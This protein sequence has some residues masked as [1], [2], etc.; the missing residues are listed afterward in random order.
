M[1]RFACGLL[2]PLGAGLLLGLRFPGLPA[3]LAQP[4]V[5]WGVPLSLVGLLLRAGLHAEMVLAAVVTA[6]ASAIGLLLVQRCPPL[7]RA[8][9]S[10]CLRLGSVVGNTG[11][12]GIPV[13]LALLPP[14]ALGFSITYDLVGT[15]IT[16]SAGPLLVAG[17]PADGR[18]AAAALAASP[19]F[20]GLTL[21][22]ALQ[23]SPWGTALGTLLWGPSQVLV[24]VALSVVGMRLGVTLGHTWSEARA[25]S[26]QPTASRTP[27]RDARADR[28]LPVAVA[29]K[30]LVLPGVMLGLALLLRLPPL[31][32][33]ALVLQAGAPTAIS[34]LLLAEL[35]GRDGEA[36][37]QLVLVTTLLALASVPLWWRL[38]LQVPQVA[39][40]AS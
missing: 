32:R 34:A 40:L 16:W 10:P 37:A 39:A 26:P 38:L 19:A 18:Q 6:L 23:L 2:L 14:A 1:L 9:P 7:R 12:F 31:V 22:L 13:A 29:F 25:T 27:A 11:Y 21:A 35:V 4:L 20:R 33:D 17:R 28:A 5:Q 3:R 24:L 36:T 30:L 8:L 15:L